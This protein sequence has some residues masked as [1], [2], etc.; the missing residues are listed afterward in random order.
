MVKIIYFFNWICIGLIALFVLLLL[1]DPNKGGGDAATKGL[2]TAFIFLG[3]AALA[4]LLVLNLLP[5]QWSKYLASV[6]VL[7]PFLFYVGSSKWSAYKRAER[8][9]IEAARPIFDD[10][11][12]DRLAR[13]IEA[14]ESQVLQKS[15]PSETLELVQSK[16]LLW[17]ALQEASSSGFRSDEK[18][19]CLRLLLDAGAP[20]DTL[21]KGETP[22]QSS[23]ANTGNAAVLRLLFERG[24][25][26]NARDPHFNRPYIFDAIVSHMDPLAAV[27]TFLEFGADP[28]ATAIFD[29]EDGPITPLIR[30]AQFDRWKICATLIEKGA[31]PDFKTPNGKSCAFY[32]EQA[33]ESIRQYG[34]PETQADFARLQGLV[35]QGR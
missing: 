11:N 18:L 12:V 20:F 9:R 22:V 3:L 4:I 19:Q 7:A 13:L 32:L 33:E 35:E 23:A 28:N 29:D 26:P 17:F 16:D 6:L 27:Q 25:D 2:G 34:S 31:H 8:A 15:L 30:A 10:P 24:A 21:L 14:G 1:L 5:W